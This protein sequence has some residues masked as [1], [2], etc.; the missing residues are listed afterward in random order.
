MAAGRFFTSRSRSSP[1]CR[2]RAATVAD[3]AAEKPGR[4]TSGITLCSSK[5]SPSLDVVVMTESVSSECWV[6][7]LQAFL[8]HD[9]V[10]K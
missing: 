6:V 3:A 8:G 5:I 9:L 7:L 2:Q 10:G 1:C 4:E